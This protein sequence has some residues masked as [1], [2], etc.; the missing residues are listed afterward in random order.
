MDI[1]RRGA[2]PRVRSCLDVL[3]IYE[4]MLARKCAAARA[5][6]QGGE[7]EIMNEKRQMLHH[8]LAAIAYRVQK[9]ASRSARWLRTLS[10]RPR[11]AHPAR[12]RLPHHERSRLRPN[13]PRRRCI[14]SRVPTNWTEDPN[15]LHEMLEECRPTS[16]QRGIAAG[17]HGGAVASGP[18][19]R[20]DDSRWA[21]G[22]VGTFW[23]GRRCG[24]RIYIMA[25]VSASNLS[26]DQPNP[27][28]PDEE[29][30]LGPERPPE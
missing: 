14:S 3:G 21:V 2:A 1:P 12:T 17:D 15:A 5:W 4:L 9:G 6:R 7:V 28:S 16:P 22:D 26:E 8:F 18:A 29:W 11:R 13:V 19:V 20:R 24:R 23:R 30:P 10:R 25:A 27:V